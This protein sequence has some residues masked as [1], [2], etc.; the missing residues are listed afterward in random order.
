MDLTISISAQIF[1]EE[2]KIKTKNLSLLSL[3]LKNNFND[4]EG[5]YFSNSNL[6][7]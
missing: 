4:F 5:N 3:C 2:K 6:E 1:M 7:S